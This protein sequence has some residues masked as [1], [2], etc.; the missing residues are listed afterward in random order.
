MFFNYGQ[1]AAS[2]ELYAVSKI[3]KHYKIPYIIRDIS[4]LGKMGGSALTDP[5]IEIPKGIYS[6]ETDECWT[7]A[8]NLVM[9][10]IAAA[11]AD[12]WG[13]REQLALP[14]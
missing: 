14:R 5:N 13:S 9:L 2:A 1:K 11:Y 7:P 12:R 6:C 10:S 4:W 3:A 8:R